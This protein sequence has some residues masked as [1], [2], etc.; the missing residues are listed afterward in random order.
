MHPAKDGEE[1]Y[2]EIT[3]NYFLN[4]ELNIIGKRYVLC[5][6]HT[7]WFLLIKIRSLL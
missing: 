5:D 1:H 4:S 2:C 3:H 7:Y 6:F